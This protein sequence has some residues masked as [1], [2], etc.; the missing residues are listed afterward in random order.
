MF[1]FV[2]GLLVLSLSVATAQAISRHSAHNL[3][4]SSIQR[5]IDREKET[6]LRYPS[7]NN[8]NIFIFDRYVAETRFCAAGESGRM[9]TVRSKDNSSCPVMRCFPYS[10][11]GGR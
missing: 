3:S 7:T 2:L 11:S 8:P 10:T 4:C 5:I 6:I 1:R 9:S